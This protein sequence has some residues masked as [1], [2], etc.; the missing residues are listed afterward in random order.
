MNLYITYFYFLKET[1]KNELSNK[2]KF[3]NEIATIDE[4]IKFIQ[5]NFITNDFENLQKFLLFLKEAKSGNINNSIFKREK[6]KSEDKVNKLN[7]SNFEE[8][9]NNQIHDS[10]LENHKK[11]NEVYNNFKSVVNKYDNYADSEYIKQINN[12]KSNLNKTTLEHIY[13]ILARYRELLKEYDQ[14]CIELD[15]F[16]SSLTNDLNDQMEK[17]CNNL[18]MELSHFQ[19]I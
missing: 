14:K 7:Y 6:V 16:N 9:N 15:F 4:W 8:K 10:Y 11:T 5:E 1:L 2:N 18:Q 3:P 19:I 17:H 12:Q 13:K